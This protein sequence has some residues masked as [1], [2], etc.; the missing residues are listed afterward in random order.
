MAA[1]SQ[2]NTPECEVRAVQQ[3]SDCLSG[4]FS[5]I[6]VIIIIITVCF[7]LNRCLEARC[8]RNDNKGVDNPGRHSA[9]VSGELAC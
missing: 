2:A 3:T 8:Y 5:T 9:A 6:T 7:L 4:S 1:A